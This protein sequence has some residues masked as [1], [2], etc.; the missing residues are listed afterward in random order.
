[1]GQQL[2]V[3]GQQLE[4]VGQQLCR[5]EVVEM[6]HRQTKSKENELSHSFICLCYVIISGMLFR[7]G[8]IIPIPA[9]DVVR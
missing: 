5:A 9:S 3:V 1:V 4:V 2:E 6:F 8:G 7:Y